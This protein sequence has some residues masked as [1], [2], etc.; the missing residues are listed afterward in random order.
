VKIVDKWWW[1]EEAM[2]AKK[3]TTK[4]AK[5]EKTREHEA[6]V[7]RYANAVE[8]VMSDTIDPL[9]RI[10]SKV[11][12]ELVIPI[13]KKHNL[14]FVSTGANYLF[15]RINCSPAERLTIGSRVDAVAKNMA[16]VAEAFDVL[17]IQISEGMDDYLGYYVRA[18]EQP[19]RRHARSAA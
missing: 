2:K 17:D 12:R 10:G 19:Q 14:S 7:F 5:G 8:E 16:D 15:T 4:S 6:T 9:S 1:T 11:R 13:C 3:K 18:V